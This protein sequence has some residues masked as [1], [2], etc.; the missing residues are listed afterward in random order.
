MGQRSPSKERD[1]SVG[2][3]SPDAQ[4]YPSMEPSS[5]A[6]ARDFSVSPSPPPPPP[7]PLAKKKSSSIWVPPPLPP[8]LKKMQCKKKEKP[9]PDKLACDMTPEELTAHVQKEVADH[10]RPKK[11]E[12]KEPVDPAGKNFFLGIMCQ[13]MKN[14]RLSVYD[15]SIT[16]SWEKKGN[17]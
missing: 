11:P 2:S 8:R 16:K 13:P 17:C 5:P 10:F 9:A 4:R 7:P 6:A 14:E 15:H 12:P 1:P 3:R